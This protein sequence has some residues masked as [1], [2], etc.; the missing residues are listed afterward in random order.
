MVG[1]T[2]KYILAYEKTLKK[3]PLSNTVRRRTGSPPP[4]LRGKTPRPEA[5]ERLR[6]VDPCPWSDPTPTPLPTIPVP[7]D[8]PTL[9]RR[10]EFGTR[11]I[12]FSKKHHRPLRTNAPPTRR[13]KTA[14]RAPNPGRPSSGGWYSSSPSSDVFCSSSSFS[15]VEPMFG[16]SSVLS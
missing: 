9:T 4:Y 16:A 8:A 11:G 7:E 1:V 6:G 10:C 2:K 14:T 13:A 3:A 5:T 12:L 15:S